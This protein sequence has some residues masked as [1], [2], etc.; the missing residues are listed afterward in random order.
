MTE[1][2]VTEAPY[3]EARP[4]SRQLRV[5]EYVDR[6]LPELMTALASDDI[7]KT[8]AQALAKAVAVDGDHVT[9]KTTPPVVISA[10]NAELT[11]AWRVDFGTFE[12]EGSAKVD[13][14]VVQSGQEPLTEVLV[15][16]S[17]TDREAEAVAS[18]THRFLDELTLRLA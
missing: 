9:V 8:L 18:A 5:C 4:G 10:I 13:L 14:L 7:E 2:T 15:T 6:S 11:V 12:R 16:T 1:P 17:V 3:Q